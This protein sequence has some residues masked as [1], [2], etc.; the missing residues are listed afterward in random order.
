[1][2]LFLVDLAIRFTS[3]FAHRKAV[4]KTPSSVCAAAVLFS[5]RPTAL[6]TVSLLIPF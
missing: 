4:R 2:P 6:V 1:M 5:P 3:K